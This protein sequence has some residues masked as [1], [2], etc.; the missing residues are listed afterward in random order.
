M[1]YIVSESWFPAGKS[2]EIGKLYLEAMKK[3]PNDRSIAKPI[4]NLR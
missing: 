4:V 1:V 2:A 3:Y